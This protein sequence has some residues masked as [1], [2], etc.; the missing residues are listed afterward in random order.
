MSKSW[1]TTWA[2]LLGTF[3]Q[4]AIEGSAPYAKWPGDMRRMIGANYRQIT[5]KFI[6]Y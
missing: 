5:I 1:K 6:Y 4:D 2:I 3:C